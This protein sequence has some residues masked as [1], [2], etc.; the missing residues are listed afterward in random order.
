LNSF[1]VP[2]GKVGV[3]GNPNDVILP[4]PMKTPNAQHYQILELYK[5]MIEQTSGVSDFY[6]KGVGSPKGNR[7]ATGINQVIGESNFRFK[8]F[9]RNLE[10]DIW[11]PMLEMVSSMILQ[12]LPDQISQMI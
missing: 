1:N 10:L 11:Q 7:T 3:S 12:F 5:G 4:L 8:L 9:I 6:S 2:G